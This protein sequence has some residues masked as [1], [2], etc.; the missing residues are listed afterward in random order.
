M[1]F[2]A[3][4]PPVTGELSLSNGASLG[5]IRECFF[6]LREQNPRR[7]KKMKAGERRVP[8]EKLSFPSRAEESSSAGVGALGLNNAESG[9]RCSRISRFRDFAESRPRPNGESASRASS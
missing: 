5:F 4:H 9:Q 3:V 8:G 6:S 2:P 7:K 1:S